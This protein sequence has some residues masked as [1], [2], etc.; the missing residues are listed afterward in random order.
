MPSIYLS[1]I[2]SNDVFLLLII[3]LLVSVRFENE[4]MEIN[5]FVSYLR[6]KYPDVLMA[7]DMRT[8][9]DVINVLEK[10]IV[11]RSPRDLLLFEN[12]CVCNCPCNRSSTN[13][14]TN[15]TR[16]SF[17]SNIPLLQSFLQPH[18]MM[19]HGPLT[20]EHL[21]QEPMVPGGS[22]VHL[23]NLVSKTLLPQEFK[24]FSKPLVVSDFLKS[25]ISVLSPSKSSSLSLLLTESLPPISGFETQTDSQSIQSSFS[26]PFPS[27]KSPLQATKLYSNN[28]GLTHTFLNQSKNRV[29]LEPRSPNANI[30]SFSTEDT[31]LLQMFQTQSATQQLSVPPHLPSDI[32]SRSGDEMDAAV[33]KHLMDSLILTT[34]LLAE[35]PS[36]VNTNVHSV[37]SIIASTVSRTT[38]AHPW[39]NIETSFRPIVTPFS[40]K[41]V[42]NIHSWTH[43]NVFNIQEHWNTPILTPRVFNEAYTLSNVDVYSSISAT[44]SLSIYKAASK[45][46]DPALLNK[47]KRTV[48]KKLAQIHGQPVT[49]DL[50]TED[51]FKTPTDKGVPG[52]TILQQQPLRAVSP[53]TEATGTL[54]SSQAQKPVSLRDIFV[55]EI[56]NV[57]DSFFLV[58]EFVPEHDSVNRTKF[59]QNTLE[60]SKIYKASKA[61]HFISL[62]ILSVMVLEVSD[63]Y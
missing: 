61:L 29:N 2:R 62:S 23:T 51:R 42:H 13:L 21:T 16:N 15:V 9:S 63:L 6:E 59:I 3:C 41:L 60:Y 36:G 28:K 39:S 56:N 11:L 17:D 54:N 48:S 35:N 18:R 7:D 43:S 19:T 55:L 4:E 34:P 50:I 38:A 22:N 1:F 53:T 40:S 31:P 58:A 5:R 24:S 49:S 10:S 26:K 52:V 57:I 44:Q 46:S 8:M 30:S 20:H 37:H 33:N 45:P 25:F 47:M 12:H 27:T 32:F 14:D